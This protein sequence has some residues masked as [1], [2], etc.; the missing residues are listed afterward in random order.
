M[1]GSPAAPEIEGD[2]K[3]YAHGIILREL[4]RQAVLLAARD[5]LARR[6]ATRCSASHWRGPPRTPSSSSSRSSTPRGSAKPGI[7]RLGAAGKDAPLLLDHAV[8]LGA[9]PKLVTAAEELSAHRAPRRPQ[10][11]GAGGRRTAGGP[12]PRCRRASRRSSPTR[13]TPSCSRPSARCTA[14]SARRRV[15]RGSPRSPEAYALLGVLNEFHWHP[16]HKAF[17]A[18]GAALRPALCG[19]TPDDPFALWNRAFV[20]ALVGMHFG[21]EA[22]LDRAEAEARTKAGAAPAAPN[23]S[24]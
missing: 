20:R 14:P 1:L 23:G 4:I 5:E 15:P 2:G 8:D 22:D 13:A 18:R 7:R 10:E 17:K 9:I 21:A 12:R 11:A 3:P 6:L 24:R 16:A 19:R